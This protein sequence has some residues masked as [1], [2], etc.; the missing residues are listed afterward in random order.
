[1][2]CILLYL[3][4]IPGIIWA[5]PVVLVSYYDAFNGSPF[6]NS[7]RIA[8]RLALAFKD[9]DI[10]L[11]LCALN[12]VFDKSYAQIE[13]CLKELESKP[14]LVLGLGESNCNLKIELLGR[15]RDKTF[16]PDNEGNNRESVLIIPEAEAEIGFTYPLAQMYCA[17]PENEREKIEVSNNAGSFV[18]NN[19][20]FKLSYYYPDIASGFIHVPSHHCRGLDKKSDAAFL[21]LK[22]MI[23]KAV[24][25]NGKHLSRL[26][27]NKN[28]LKEIRLKVENKDKCLHQFF[29][30]ARGV[31]EKGFW[32]F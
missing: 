7:Q 21:N 29:K 25:L 16:G 14:V 13:N 6:N 30:R 22:L 4:F 24:D 8:N 28:E 26:P 12:T 18:C 15:N 27:K 10:E 2:K 3:L 5:R 31:D 20:A 17:V 19:T 9:S 11:R 32:P 1:M 23:S